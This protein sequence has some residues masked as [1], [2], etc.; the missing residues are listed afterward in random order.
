MGRRHFS[1]RPV[2]VLAVAIATAAASAGVRAQTRILFPPRPVSVEFR[3]LG[4]DGAPVLD[5]SASE[6][7]LKVDGKVRTLQSLDLVRFDAGAARAAAGGPL[8]EPFATNVDRLLEA[9]SPGDRVGLLNI[10]RGGTN[11]GLTTDREQIRAG[12]AELVGLGTRGQTVNDARCRTIV[13]LQAL[14]NLLLAVRGG[15]SSTIAFFSSGVAPPDTNP[16]VTLGQSSDLCVVKVDYFDELREAAAVAG[17]NFYAIH[18]FNDTAISL[19]GSTNDLVAGLE[20]LA[21]SAN[22]DTIR[23]TTQDALSITRLSRETS[24]FYRAVF[25]PEP[26]ERDDKV[27]RVDVSVSR[28]GVSLRTGTGVPIAKALPAKG[29]GQSKPPSVT[30]LLRT[31]DVRRDLPLRAAG[32]P[33]QGQTKDIVKVVVVVE[34]PDPSDEISAA[35]VGLYD[36]RGRLSAQVT[37]RREELAN[38]PAFTAIS[39][40]PGAYRLRVAAVD[41]GGRTG[42]VDTQIEARLSKADPVTLSAMVLGTPGS[43]GFSPR[44]VFSA[45]PSLIAYFE[46]YGVPKATE[47][48]VVFELATTVDGPAVGTAQGRLQLGGEDGTWQASGG[49]GLSQVPPGDYLLRALVTIDGKTV[50]RVDRTLRKVN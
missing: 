31:S 12:V 36:E 22:G 26:D 2:C 7:T 21:G 15:T 8:P 29:A 6:V 28:R 9:L 27:H 48:S 41:R 45:E 47:V 3:A 23:L 17:I 40:K 30:D 43:E 32:Y 14:K 16:T 49:I 4:S 34:P 44:L 39:A 35:A 37:L 38:R 5:L 46:I 24:A 50:G 42:T 10:P 1:R 13:T 25:D 11:I 33:S 20:S 19:P 18:V